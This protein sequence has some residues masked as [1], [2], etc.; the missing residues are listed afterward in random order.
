M[1]DLSKLAQSLMELDDQMVACMKCGMCQAVCPVFAETMQ[2]ADVTRGKIALLEKLA[3]E[4]VT[5]ADQVNDKL[6]RCLLCGSC[7]VNCPSG[8]KIMDIFIKAR[9]IVTSYKGLSPAKKLIFKGLLNRPKLFNFLTDMSAKFQGPFAREADQAAGTASCAMLNPLLGKRHFMPLTTRPFRKDYPQVDSPRGLSGLK[10]AFF[11]GCVVDKM[12]PK[13]GHAAMK[14]FEHHGVG[15]FLPKGQACCGI[16]TLASGDA[17]TFVTLMKQN[18]KAFEDGSFDYLVTPCATCT[19]TIHEIWLKMIED[20]DPIFIEKVKDIADKTMDITAF[21]VDI[22]GV[23]AVES[24]KGGKV[25]TYHDPCHL[26]KSLGV[27]AQPRTLLKKNADY[28][29]KEMNEANRCCGSG[30][31]FNLYHYDLSK[32]IGERKKDNVRAVG[33]EVAATACPACMM[34]L[35]DM[36]SQ[37]GGGVEV[38]HV[39]EI[40]A[41]SL[42]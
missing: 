39:L 19:A 12:F 27:T 22:V 37:S 32:K 42:K 23:K 29:F 34:Q 40:Y 16:P 21:L 18:I 10:V 35:G 33:A 6:N 36:L 7:A 13:V 15:V 4:M 28:E 41:D 24:K 3:H 20:E 31:S 14:I 25:V 26:S 30:G 9:V 1:N 5:D 2:E 17:D 8:V 11:P 38:K